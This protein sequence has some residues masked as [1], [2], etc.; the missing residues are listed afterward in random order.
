MCPERDADADT[1]S[2]TDTDTDTYMN[3]DTDTDTNTDADADGDSDVNPYTPDWPS[4]DKHVAAPEWFQ[5]TKFG[6]YYHWGAFGTAM[7]GSERYPR[8]RFN[9][10]GKS[11][12]HQHHMSTH[13]D[14]YGDWG[15]EKF[16]TGGNDK[17]G[18][19]VQVAPKLKSEVGNEFTSPTALTA[20]DV[21]YTKS[22][23]DDAVYAILGGWPGNGSQVNLTAVTSSRFDV[24]AGKIFLF[25]PS[26]GSA[27]DLQFSQDGSGPHV[28]LPSMQP[29][30]AV[31]YAM[32]I[33]KSGTA[34]EPTPWLK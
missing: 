2:D 20:D 22:K 7:N 4:L 18:N 27:I 5:D 17:N 32:K 31:A 25:G 15:Y 10:D 34:P 1:D 26:D 29:Y 33:S 8:N 30:T 23:D 21:R 13:G 28:T 3:T 14:P 12:E 6:I 16:I 9:R 11:W 24:R 19:F